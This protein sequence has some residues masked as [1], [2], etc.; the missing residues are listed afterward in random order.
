MHTSKLHPTLGES[1]THTFMVSTEAERSKWLA[2]LLDAKIYVYN[3][4]KVYTY[5]VV[6]LVAR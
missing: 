3:A 2:V 4:H 1:E 6:I 5:P